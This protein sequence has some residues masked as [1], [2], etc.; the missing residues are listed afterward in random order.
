[1]EMGLGG[2]ASSGGRGKG[3]GGYWHGI[4]FLLG[5]KRVETLYY[6]VATTIHLFVATMVHIHLGSQSLFCG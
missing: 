6:L 5:E 2:E 1:M 3:G 4:N